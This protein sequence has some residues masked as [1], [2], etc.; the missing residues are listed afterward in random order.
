MYAIEVREH[1]MI[2]HSLAGDPSELVSAD[3][4]ELRGILVH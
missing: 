3:G 1:V 2:A 4:V